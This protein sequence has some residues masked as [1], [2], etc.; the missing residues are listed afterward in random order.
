MTDV[1]IYQASKTAMQ[2]GLA[3]TKK[4]I[5]E[6]VNHIKKENDPLMG[7][8]GGSETTS[9]VKMT[10]STKEAAIAYA[11][12][13]DYSYELHPLKRRALTPKSYSANFSSSR[14]ESW[15]H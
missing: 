7:W 10:F 3:K 13:H 1:I 4:W 2:S 8:N 6:F 15:T 9:Q 11:V 5:L 14:K 12:Q